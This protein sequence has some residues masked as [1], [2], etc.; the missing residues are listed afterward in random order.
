MQ[1]QEIALR[2]VVARQKC[3][4]KSEQRAQWNILIAQLVQ[5][6]REMKGIFLSDQNMIFFN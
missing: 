4:R 5:D 1:R 2:K 3:C 6:T